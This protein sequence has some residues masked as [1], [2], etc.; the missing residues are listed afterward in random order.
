[1]DS[2]IVRNTHKH[3]HQVVWGVLYQELDE[4]Q[5][6]QLQKRKFHIAKSHWHYLINDSA[7]HIK[8]SKNTFKR[9]TKPQHIEKMPQWTEGA[10]LCVIYRVRGHGGDRL[11]TN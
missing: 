3:T 5:Q 6:A 7:S 4:H 1:M 10:R 2:E 9:V 11:T 8:S